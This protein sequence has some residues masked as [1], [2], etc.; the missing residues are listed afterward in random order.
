M[1]K[2]K[3]YS[4][5]LQEIGFL[6]IKDRLIIPE[7]EPSFNVYLN[8][9]KIEVPPSFKQLAM[10]GEH[11][12]ETIWF[13]LDRYFDGEDL[14]S[15]DKV[16]GVQFVNALGEKLL[17]NV[18][19][20]TVEETETTDESTLKLGW[21]VSY[22]ITKAPGNVQLGLRCY[23][24]EG[25]NIIYDLETEY[26]SLSIGKSLYVTEGS[27]DVMNP[28]ADRLTT[29]V[30]TIQELYENKQLTELN[31]SQLGN[32]P[33]IN[34]YELPGGNTDAKNLKIQYKQLDPSTLP[35][36]TVDGVSYTIG[37]D[38][39]N[40]S[41]ITVD[42]ELK[43]STNPVQ[44]G[45]INAKITQMEQNN[46]AVISSLRNDFTTSIAATNSEIEIIKKELGNMTYIP[47]SIKS[48]DSDIKLLKKNSS[49]NGNIS[50]NWAVDGN[51]KSQEIVIQQGDNIIDTIVISDPTIRTYTYSAAATPLTSNIVCTLAI[52]DAQGKSVSATADIDFVYEVFYGVSASETFDEDSSFT[53]F[54]SILT[55]TKATVFNVFADEDE[56][57]YYCLPEEYGTPIFTVNGWTGGFD[58]AAE[59]VAYNGINYN[60]YKSQNKKLGDTTVT[61]G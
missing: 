36:I 30:A 14:A 18:D 27:V 1:I 51:V 25:N 31:Y 15:N 58:L 17:V 34:G 44:N 6:D 59:E 52:K 28:P 21:D 13:T 45:V 16:W 37:V 50:F 35:T 47:L 23:K 19:Y 48:F 5:R 8:T 49:Y 55:A 32:K 7:L 53:S 61:V 4:D 24:K 39:I 12:A 26:V 42:S 43:N 60:V 29:L 9:R 54:N 57:I 11:K 40:V 38:D 33:K 20:K 46:T 22:D 3:E 2:G 41:K 56:Y 10:Q